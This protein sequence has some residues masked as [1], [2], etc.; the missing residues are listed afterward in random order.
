MSTLAV[1]SRDSVVRARCGDGAA[2]CVPDREFPWSFLRSTAG[3]FASSV[4]RRRWCRMVAAARPPAETATNRRRELRHG[5]RRYSVT[6]A[7]APIATRSMRPARS[8]P[9]ATGMTRPFVLRANRHGSLSSTGCSSRPRA[10]CGRGE[11]ARKM[12]RRRRTTTWTS[13]PVS[14]HVRTFVKRPGSGAKR[15]GQL[16]PQVRA[17]RDEGARD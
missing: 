8:G 16:G 11:R 9:N 10:R 4:Q 17:R 2:K 6:L 1:G 14:C 15:A 3:A 5:D 7:G 12:S 13:P